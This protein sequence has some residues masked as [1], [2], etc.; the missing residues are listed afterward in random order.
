MAALGKAGRVR[1]ALRPGTSCKAPRGGLGPG[2]HSAAPWRHE[3]LDAPRSTSARGHMIPGR[4]HSSVGCEAVLGLRLRLPGRALA[5]HDKAGALGSRCGQSLP[6][7]LLPAPKCCPGHFCAA[8][9][10]RCLL[11]LPCRSE[12]T[13]W[14]ARGTWQAPSV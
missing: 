9:Q 1:G 7:C 10:P 6:E 8:L 5:C 11:P 3:E 4:H 13:H 2:L 12:G 14:H